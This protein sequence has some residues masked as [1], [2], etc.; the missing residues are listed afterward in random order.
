MDLKD[1]IPESDIVIVTLKHPSTQEVLK[2]GDGSDM[3]ISFAAPHSKEYKKVVHDQTNKRLKKMQGKNRLEIT[4][5]EIEEATLETLTK[6]TKDWDIT[7]G[8]EKI[9]L[10]DEKARE[11]YEKVFWI[12]SQV[13]QALENYF[14]FTKA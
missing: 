7:F 2:N 11:V 12:K 13:E 6:T 8:G 10:T 14:S 9:K 1:L 5:E 4:A 3:T